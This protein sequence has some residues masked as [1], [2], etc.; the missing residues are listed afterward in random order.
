MV[1]YS[2]A[3]CRPTPTAPFAASPDTAKE[4]AKPQA[5][6]P[7]HNLHGS[8]HS[9]E[10]KARLLCSQQKN[11][12]QKSTVVERE[13]ANESLPQLSDLP[14]GPSDDGH[15]PR[16]SEECGSQPLQE[17][18]VAQESQ[19]M[20]QDRGQELTGVEPDRSHVAW[21]K[22]RL[23]QKQQQGCVEEAAQR[24]EDDESA[25]E[26]SDSGRRGSHRQGI[27]SKIPHGLHNHLITGTA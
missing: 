25:H 21:M 12:P 6:Q 22:M 19:S 10:A 20:A 14:A 16:I 5:T 9:C 15:A 17:V 13:E 1:S 4:G 2:V 18:S 3:H 24:H 8:Q 23:L 7:G 11:Y 26:K 27:S